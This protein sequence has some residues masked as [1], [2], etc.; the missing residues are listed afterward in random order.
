MP[1]LKDT[2][3]NRIYSQKLT[4][5]HNKVCI[6]PP[7][8]EELVNIYESY[9]NGR[10]WETPEEFSRYDRLLAYLKNYKSDKLWIIGLLSKLKPDDDIFRP[11]YQ[12]PVPARV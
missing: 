6:Y 5:F 1:F 9:I 2:I 4:E 12:P 3:R 8:L 10:N 7:S 11:D